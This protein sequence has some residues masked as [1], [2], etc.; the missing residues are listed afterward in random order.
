MKQKVGVA[1][2]LSM[3]I[4]GCASI[5]S[6]SEWPVVVRSMPDQ[7]DVTITDVKEG[8][9][10][11]QGKTPCTLSLSSRNGY[12]SGKN[13][14]IEVSKEGFEPKTVEITS[15]LNGWYV[16]NIL[17]G[18]LVGLL[19]VD[20]LTGAMWTLDQKEVDVALSQRTASAAEEKGLSV[21]LLEDVPDHLKYR[22]KKIQ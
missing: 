20:P 5:V 19:I 10:V 13:Y 4:A 11:H 16:G 2:I 15:V 14:K 8:K 3:L 22:M 7:A 12:F 6:K 1:L 21:V 18:G 9:K 17:F